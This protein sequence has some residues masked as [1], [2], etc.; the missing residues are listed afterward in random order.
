VALVGLLGGA[1]ALVQVATRPKYQFPTETVQRGSFTLL[2]ARTQVQ[3]ERGLMGVKVLPSH[4]GMAFPMAPARPATFWMKNCLIPLDMVFLD[5]LG[6][7]QAVIH[8]FPL[9]SGSPLVYYTTRGRLNEFEVYTTLLP[10][11]ACVVEVPLGEGPA[12]V[13][14]TEG[15]PPIR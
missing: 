15:T 3:N 2:V 11:T 8:A 12:F 6:H 1:A 5:A 13:K 9:A 7:P 14:E 4:H 10:P